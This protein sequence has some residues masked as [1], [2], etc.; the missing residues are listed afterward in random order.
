MQQNNLVIGLFGFGVVGEGVYNV[1]AQTP[2]LKASVKKICVRNGE[3]PRST[4]AD[5]FTTDSSVLLDDPEINLIVELIDDAEQ[6][7]TI[8]KGALEKG[9]SVVSANKKLVAEH[10]PEL[11]AL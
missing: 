7:Y 6:A 9:K 3:K 2:S 10:L 8:V 1:L 11:V 5:L 4:S